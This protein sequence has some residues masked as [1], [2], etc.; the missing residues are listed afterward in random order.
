MSNF[1]LFRFWTPLCLRDTL[2]RMNTKTTQK[3]RK[4]RYDL[5]LNKSSG[6]GFLLLLITL[7]TTLGVLALSAS[8]A[9]SAMTQRWSAGLAHQVTIEIPARIIT[10]GNKSEKL[11]TPA[12][13]ESLT[14][15]I[16]AAITTLPAL[17]AV[18]IPT[19]DDIKSLIAPWVGENLLQS[20]LPLPGLINVTMQKD[21]GPAAI[22]E[23]RDRVKKIVPHARLDTHES[24]L[25][26]LTRFTGALQSAAL[27]LSLVIG[28]T[29]ITAI[30][31]GVR[32]RMAI[33]RAEIELLHLMG[34]ADRYISR[35]FQR[36]AL[37]LG[38][39]GALLGLTAGGLLL[40]LIGILGHDMAANLLP[41][42]T[43]SAVHILSLCALPLIIALIATLTARQ[44][45]LHVL[46]KM[47]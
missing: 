23:L 6:S 2:V 30:A 37:I 25:R 45:V 3:N 15:E 40:T 17:K 35:Q 16:A 42:F 47:P 44:T 8:F 26:D 7:M 4:H 43:L 24:W 10:P 21:A 36:H 9:L 46:S 38:L 12:D 18:D 32:A 33:H 39:K 13:I 20:D 5:P 14:A 29:M 41:D 19:P 1:S 28:L 11:L 27:L 31:G 34:A 22:E